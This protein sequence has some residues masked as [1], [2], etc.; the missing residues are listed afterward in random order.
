MTP[1]TEWSAEEAAQAKSA[2]AALVGHPLGS[3]GISLA[4]WSRCSRVS[5]PLLSLRLIPGLMSSGLIA[6]PRGYYS[7]GRWRFTR[8][9]R[10]LV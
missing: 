8:L 1:Q 9:A 6:E 4:E 2:L 3:E 7:G 10:E 5:A